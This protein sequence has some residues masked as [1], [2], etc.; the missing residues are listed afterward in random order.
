MMKRRAYE[1]FAFRLLI[2][3]GALGSIAR[4]ITM[5]RHSIHATDSG[6]SL[7]PDEPNT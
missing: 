3:F 2:G 7:T 1:H 6:L 4:D 5:Q